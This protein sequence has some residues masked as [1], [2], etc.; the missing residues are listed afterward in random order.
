MVAQV[1]NV[2]CGFGC[3]FLNIIAITLLVKENIYLLPILPEELSYYHDLC[4][5]EAC[6]FIRIIMYIYEHMLHFF[7]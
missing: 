6:V 3:Y 1:I 7:L 2:N 5:C 4:L